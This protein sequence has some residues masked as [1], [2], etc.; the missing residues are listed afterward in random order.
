MYG[1]DA[2]VLYLAGT[3]ERWAETLADATAGL[4]TADKQ[5]LWRDNAA[6]FYVLD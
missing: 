2:P 4:S 6:A 1:S 3:Y 5:K